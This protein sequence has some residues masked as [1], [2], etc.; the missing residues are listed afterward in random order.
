ME[1]KKTI[2]SYLSQVL[3]I[4]SITVLC[5][6]MF[7]HFFGESAREISALY[8][9]GGEGIPLEII[10]E[11]FLLS[12]IVVVLQYLFVTDLLFK[13][14]P[15][16]ARIVCMVV[17]ILVVMCGFILLFD[18]FPADMWQPWVLFLVCFA[19]CFFVSAGISALKT[20]IENKKLMEG[21]ENV[22]RHWEAEYEKT[23]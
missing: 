12:I 16:L 2:F 9:M 5:M 15:V 18:W 21:L 1:E 11:L 19:V 7:T 8:R 4:F 22:K 10:L 23:D 17:S 3:V 6:T 14:M 20:R 13:K